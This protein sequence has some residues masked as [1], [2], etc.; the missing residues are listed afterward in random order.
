[1]DLSKGSPG[2][3]AQWSKTDR[4]K[5]CPWVCKRKSV[6]KPK[7]SAFVDGKRKKVRLTKQKKEEKSQMQD[8]SPIT[9]KNARTV[10]IGDPGLGTS[11]VT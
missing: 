10:Y 11:C 9:G 2:T 7:E 5:H 1:M 3:I 6:S 8:Y 4:Q